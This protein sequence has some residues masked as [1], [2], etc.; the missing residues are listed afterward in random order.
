MHNITRMSRKI[1]LIKTRLLIAKR[2]AGCGQGTIIFYPLRIDN[3]KSICLGDEVF[4][5]E[6]AWLYGSP[7]TVVSLRVGSGTVIGHFSH[8]VATHNV[9]I[10]EKVLIAD[11]VFISDC[12]HEFKDAEVAIVDQPVSPIDP[13]FIGDGT[14]IG[15][16]VSV[17]GATIG[18]HCVIGANSVVTRDIPD[19][20]VAIG[21]PARVLSR[22]DF[23]KQEWVKR[24]WSELSKNE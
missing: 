6:G 7:D 20:S 4:I 23:E 18:K 8:I 2:M 21:A 19:Y 16:G 14:W 12:T 15:E 10:G 3:I 24:N 1:A 13:V 9:T 11:K 22:F 17:I 5:A